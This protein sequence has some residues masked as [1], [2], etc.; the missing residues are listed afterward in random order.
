MSVNASQEAFS[1]IEIFSWKPY[2]HHPEP[3]SFAEHILWKAATDVRKY[4]KNMKQL[5]SSFQLFFP[6]E[7]ITD[8][9]ILSDKGLKIPVS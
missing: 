9:K 8:F 3:Q 1:V 5:L 4:T 6:V 2:W 7:R